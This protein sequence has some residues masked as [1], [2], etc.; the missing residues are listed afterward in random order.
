MTDT[1]AED[2]VKGLYNLGAVRREI[3]RH[4]LAELGTHGFTALATIHRRGPLR[5]SAVAHELGV[6]ISVA[7]RQVSHLIAAG[8]V[9]REPDPEDGRAYLVSSTPDG[10]QVLR[11]SHRR[12][13][14]AVAD[15]IGDWTGEEICGLADGLARLTHDFAVRGA[16]RAP[17]R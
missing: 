2:L 11:E 6:D 10:L 16:G 15:A 17:V 8:Y 3:A 5:V 13:V 9:R 14:H 1:H 7:S 12:M 4:A